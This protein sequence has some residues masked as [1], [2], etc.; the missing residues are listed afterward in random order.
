MLFKLIN[1]AGMLAGIALLATFAC[2]ALHIFPLHIILGFTTVA[3]GLAHFGLIMYKNW[4]IR[5]RV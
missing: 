4:K 5:K 1:I 2:G 3:L